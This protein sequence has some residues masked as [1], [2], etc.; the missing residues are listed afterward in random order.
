[1]HGGVDLTLNP[2]QLQDPQ[3][4]VKA[5]TKADR[6]PEKFV[7]AFLK[8]G[9][10]ELK[11]VKG[12][13]KDADWSVNDMNGALSRAIEEN[14]AYEWPGRKGAKLY[15][16]VAPPPQLP[17]KAKKL[18]K[19]GKNKS[20]TIRNPVCA[21]TPLRENAR[22]VINSPPLL[23]PP[24]RG[25]GRKKKMKNQKASNAINKRHPTDREPHYATPAPTQFI[26]PIKNARLGV[27]PM[28]EPSPLIGTPDVQSA[29]GR[30]SQSRTPIGQTLLHDSHPTRLATRPTFQHARHSDTPDIPT[31]QNR[32]HAGIVT[33][34]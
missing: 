8:P 12:S 29:I 33:G 24:K 2:N 15:A 18:T 10:R 27:L 16:T 25:Q 21:R 3:S 31:H 32:S 23:I 22:G 20:K 9:P 14:L 26:D 7:Q 11:A 19:S 28:G 1:M 30:D 6:T 5:T 4:A 13:A 17:I 34:H